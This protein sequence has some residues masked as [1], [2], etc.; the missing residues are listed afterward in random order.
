MGILAKT[1]PIY[2]GHFPSFLE[3]F[4]PDRFILCG[5]DKG[6]DSE[7]LKQC[8]MKVLRV[9][10]N[11][12]RRR[13]ILEAPLFKRGGKGKENFLQLISWLEGDTNPQAFYFR[14]IRE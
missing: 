5:N 3:I 7:G 6:L 12:K 10:K 8:I 1:I 2:F 11:P 14:Q 9:A 4:N 13:E